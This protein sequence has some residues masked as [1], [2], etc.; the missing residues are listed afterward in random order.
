MKLIKRYLKKIA[1]KLGYQ[2]TKISS[3]PIERVI[4]ESNDNNLNC[5]VLCNN[6]KYKMHNEIYLKYRNL[7]DSDWI[8]LLY[9]SVDNQI[10]DNIKFP[11]FPE[12]NIQIRMIGNHG[13]GALY[14]PAYIY[15]EIRRIAKQQNKAFDENTVFLDFACGYGRH[16]RFFMK[17]IYPGNLYGS[18]V[19]HDFIGICRSTF[20]CNK[21]SDVL[22]DINNPFP[23]LKY[24]NETFDFIMA[25]SLFSHLSEEAHLAWLSEY[26][27]ILK[28]DGLLFL[29][30]RQQFFL[31]NLGKSIGIG[32]VDKYELYLLEKLG[33]NSV[34]ERF[35]NGEYIFHPSGGGKEMTKDFYGDTVIPTSYILSKWV[36]LF[37]IIE[38]YE[39]PN[40]LYQAFICLKKKSHR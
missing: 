35:N 30:I 6:G 1:K 11:A 3:N 14:E 29:T 18:D 13:K 16:T 27:R 23:P 12:K 28:P 22:F 24:N 9:A 33:N 20:S 38:H 31:T 4:M 36:N 10:I 26:Y 2:I 21:D 37:D 25:Y 8:K 5:I 40:K 7:C 15:Q 39:D 19:T 32:N 17:D 34:L